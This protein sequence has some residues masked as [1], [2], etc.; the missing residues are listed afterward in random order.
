MLKWILL[1]ILVA[2]IAW[3]TW[4]KPR[5]T[6]TILW[7]LTATVLGSAGLLLVL[8]TEF[9]P[10]IIWMSL[11]TPLIWAGLML[12]CYWDTRAWR[13]ATGMIAITVLGVIAV[14]VVPPPGG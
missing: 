13:P 14:I 1:A 7:S 4:R 6:A 3:S 9:K 5:L 12:W 8:P 10:T 2:F 11:A